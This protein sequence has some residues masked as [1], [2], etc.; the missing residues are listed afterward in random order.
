MTKSKNNLQDI[1]NTKKIAVVVVVIVITGMFLSANT[2]INPLIAKSS[3]SEGKTS[4][5]TDKK[6]NTANAATT[7]STT[8][9]SSSEQNDYKN[10]Q[11]CLSTAAN[12]K[13]FATKTDIE[14]C[15]RPIYSPATTSSTGTNSSSSTS[16]A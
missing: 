3:K 13:G 7:T 4:K 14:N 10:F 5:S 8:S 16:I 6:S 2:L 12:A 11:K 15:F 9:S 1:R